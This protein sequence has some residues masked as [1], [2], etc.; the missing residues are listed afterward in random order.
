M[1]FG[2]SMRH[3]SHPW[4]EGAAL[5]F[6]ARFAPASVPASA[7]VSV[8]VSARVLVLVL[9]F[10]SMLLAAGGASAQISPAP[11]DE[12]TRK[13]APSAGA[14]GALS[15]MALPK[16]KSADFFGQRERLLR[17]LYI[18]LEDAK[19]PETAKAIA[20]TIER[21]W[22]NSG[23][24]TV[25]LLLARSGLAMRQKRPELAIKLLD[26]AIRLA[27]NYAEA[28]N[29][30][31]YVYVSRRDYVFALRDLRQVFALS[32]QHYKALAGFGFVLKEIGEDETALRAFR[33]ALKVH[34]F[35]EQVRK[36][37]EELARKIEGRE[38]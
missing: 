19:N 8:P 13:P 3:N 18:K 30:R 10:C 23:S 15:G 7:P 12:R 24:D 35:L 21:I 9:L 22:N 14:G 1:V 34:P 2:Q 31:A 11:G 6:A 28:W 20:A 4:R 33:A 32:P 25:D 17:D 5:G 27:P 26:A 38:I 29:R 37:M 16:A 36:A